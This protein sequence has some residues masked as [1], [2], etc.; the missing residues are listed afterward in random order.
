MK[1]AGIGNALMDVLVV[2][3]GEERLHELRLAKGGMT[4]V[5]ERR[6]A[7]ISRLTAAMHPRVAT[8]GSAANAM[9]ALSRLGLSPVFIGRTGRDEMGQ[10]LRACYREAGIEARLITA[11]GATGVAHTFITPDGERTFATCLAAAAGLRAEEVSDEMLHGIDLLHIEGYLVQDHA[12]IEHVARRARELGAT[13]SIDLS[14]YNIVEADRPFFRHLVTEYIDI[15]FAN[16]EES[17]AFTGLSDPSE[18]LAALARVCR[19]AVV[20]LGSRG[21]IAQRGETRAEAR[22]EAIAHVVDTTAAGDFFA[23]GFLAAMARG[24][25]LDEC[26]ATGNSAGGLVIQ[27]VGTQVPEEAWGALRARAITTTTR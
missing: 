22:A 7:E 13:L 3:D 18:A 27:V 14:S 4:L 10:R 6:G 16:E 12:L 19:T 8:G 2:L 23:G 9:L 5:D 11:D 26:L 21:A 15:V 25:Q 20:K 24:R 17:R 1:I